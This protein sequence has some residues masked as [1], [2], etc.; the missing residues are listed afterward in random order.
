MSSLWDR[1][2][3]VSFYFSILIIY[4][5]LHHSVASA[6]GWNSGICINTSPV[7][8]SGI[9]TYESPLECCENAYAGQ[10]SGA[11]IF[12][13]P[14]SITD[15]LQIVWFP[16]YSDQK[17]VSTEV[18]PRNHGV[19]GYD[20]QLQCCLAEYGHGKDTDQCFE[21]LPNPSTTKLDFYYPDY[22][23]FIVR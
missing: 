8:N 2:Y 23:E 18:V 7:P 14:S 5:C 13:L 17:C 15:T 4:L 10:S 19:P 16:V 9:V 21:G 20:T 11:Y 6:R 22:S 1:E 3:D 12:S